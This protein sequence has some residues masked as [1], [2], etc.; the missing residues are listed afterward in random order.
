[1]SN[2][3]YLPGYVVLAGMKMGWMEGWTSYLLVVAVVLR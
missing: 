3:E 1:M 2:Q